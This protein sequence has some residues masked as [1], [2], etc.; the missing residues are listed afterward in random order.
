M[1]QTQVT[2]RSTTIMAKGDGICI[3]SIL[4]ITGFTSMNM[5]TAIIRGMISD[6]QSFITTRNITTPMKEMTLLTCR[7]ITSLLF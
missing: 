7:S 5:K 6:E 1:M 4:S 3:F 2:R